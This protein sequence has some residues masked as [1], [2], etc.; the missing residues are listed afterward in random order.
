MLRTLHTEI[1]IWPKLEELSVSE[2]ELLEMTDP[3]ATSP[4]VI[5]MVI[6]VPGGIGFTGGHGEL[7]CERARIH[8]R[9]SRRLAAAIP[10]D[11]GT[12]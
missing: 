1:T 7:V 11:L 5:V 3:C 2:L 12:R 10:D 9:L 8:T 4:F 6:L